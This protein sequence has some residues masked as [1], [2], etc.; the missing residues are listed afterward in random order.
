MSTIFCIWLFLLGVN[1][2]MCIPMKKKKPSPAPEAP[3][4]VGTI[5]DEVP[6]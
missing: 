3:R 1:I 4:T 2:G 6:R 5:V